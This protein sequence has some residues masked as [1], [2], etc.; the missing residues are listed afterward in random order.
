MPR[1]TYTIQVIESQTIYYEIE[2]DS[3]ADARRIF[4]E[5]EC[6]EPSQEETLGS[7]FI[8]VRDARGEEVRLP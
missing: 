7:E 5:S 4:D 3:A 1:E 8:C 2:A 6:L